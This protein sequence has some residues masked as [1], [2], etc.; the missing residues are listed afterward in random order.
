MRVAGLSLYKVEAFLDPLYT[1]V[2]AIDPT[3]NVRQPFLDT[4]HAHLQILN[5]VPAAVHALLDPNQA[6]LDLL[7]DRNDGIGDFARV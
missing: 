1:R 6:R 4:R 5:V 3:V 7:Q 2:E